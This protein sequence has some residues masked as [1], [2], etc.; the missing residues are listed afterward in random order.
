MFAPYHQ[1]Q[2]HDR[3]YSETYADI[4]AVSPNQCR[5]ACVCDNLSTALAYTRNAVL[6]RLGTHIPQKIRGFI[7]AKMVIDHAAMFDLQYPITIDA[8][9]APHLVTVSRQLTHVPRSGTCHAATESCRCRYIK[10]SCA[11]PIARLLYAHLHQPLMRHDM[12]SP[13][14]RHCHVQPALRQRVA[15]KS[16]AL[17]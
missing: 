13:Y 4:D 1:R 10:D 6:R 11:C 3:H 15:A 2:P 12:L 14:A 8:I 16:H 5:L 9:E 7:S 17:C